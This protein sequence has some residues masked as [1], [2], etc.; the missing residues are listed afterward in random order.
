M[1]V[2]MGEYEPAQLTIDDAEA[3]REAGMELLMTTDNK[4]AAFME[5]GDIFC[6]CAGIEKEYC[7]TC[8]R[9]LFDTERVFLN[10]GQTVCQ[11][12]MEQAGG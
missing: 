12:C 10:N 8:R 4:I 9:M 6:K 1:K 2:R 7:A 3:L 11:D 5:I